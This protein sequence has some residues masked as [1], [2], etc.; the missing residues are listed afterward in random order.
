MLINELVPLPTSVVI[1]FVGA[2]FGLELSKYDKFFIDKKGAAKLLY[3]S[4]FGFF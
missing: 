1:P 4:V 2:G 3:K